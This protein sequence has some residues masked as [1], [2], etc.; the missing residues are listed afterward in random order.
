MLHETSISPFDSLSVQN[1][2]VQSLLLFLPFNTFLYSEGESSNFLH[3]LLDAER[4]LVDKTYLD[5]SDILESMQGAQ[6]RIV[7]KKFPNVFAPHQRESES[8]SG[9]RP[10]P[11]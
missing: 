11:W 4:Y 5:V 10:G 8:L 1:L 7:R 6:V 2:E 3:P 9:G